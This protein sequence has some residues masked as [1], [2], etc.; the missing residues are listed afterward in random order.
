MVRLRFVA[1]LLVVALFGSSL[2]MGDDK[3]DPIIVR[4]QLPPNYK[5]LGLTPKQK[6]DILKIRA[7]YAAEIQELEQKIKDLKKQEKTAYESVLTAAQKARLQEIRN[8]K[9]EADDDAP[10]PVDKKKSATAKDKK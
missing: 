10:V 9:K 2:L 8:G 7:K 3:V 4:V 6:N 1:P 5:Q